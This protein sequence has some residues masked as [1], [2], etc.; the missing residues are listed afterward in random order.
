[1]FFFVSLKTLLWCYENIK[2]L[3]FLRCFTKKIKNVYKVFLN[4]VS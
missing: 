2:S 3:L 1:M 4:N